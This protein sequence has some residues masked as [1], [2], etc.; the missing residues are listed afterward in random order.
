MLLEA[1]EVEGGRLRDAGIRI[2]AFLS[3]FIHSV[4]NKKL[5]CFVRKVLYKS[6]FLSLYYSHSRDGGA[7]LHV[8]AVGHAGLA[9][10]PVLEA[11][12]YDGDGLMGKK[13]AAAGMLESELTHFFQFLFSAC[14]GIK[15]FLWVFIHISVVYGPYVEPNKRL[16]QYPL[17]NF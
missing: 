17:G 8:L 10:G 15:V 3:V 1:E 13:V 6:K 12:L 4:D 11:R 2:N 9:V 5:I 14:V 7:L 16:L